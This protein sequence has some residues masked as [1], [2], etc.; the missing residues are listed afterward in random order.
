[1]T[2]LTENRLYPIHAFRFQVDFKEQL[3][4][5]QSEGD[6]ILLCSGAFSGDAPV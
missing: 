1:M 2:E 4:G 3:I 6:D 5:N